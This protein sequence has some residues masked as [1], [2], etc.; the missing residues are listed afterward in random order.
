[1]SDKRLFNPEEAAKYLG[2]KL[3]MVRK[4]IQ[5]KK[6][7]FFKIGKLIRFDKVELDKWVDIKKAKINHE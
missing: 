5:E 6:I 2:L 1:M 4:L 7:V 3:S